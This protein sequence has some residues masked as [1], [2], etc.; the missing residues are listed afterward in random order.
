M[1]NKIRSA[2]VAA[3]TV[4]VLLV[5]SARMPA[6]TGS[7]GGATMTLP[8]TDVAGNPFFCQIA[9]AFVSGLTNGT[10]PTTYSPSGIVPR[11][12]MAAFITRTL[13]SAL[14]RGSR[15]AALRQRSL[16]NLSLS[17]IISIG[18][19]TTFVESDGT[20]LWVVAGTNVVRVRASDGT[21]LDT[22]T[23]A[24]SATALLVA[25][26][27]IFLAGP[28]HLYVIDPTMPG[29]SLSNRGIGLGGESV[30]ITT[31]GS[32]IWTAN[33][34][35]SVSRVH[36]DTGASSNFA[37]GFSKP[38]GILFDGSNLW[39]T[40]QGDNALKK[41][42]A[43]GNVIQNVP[44]GTAPSSPVFD[45]ANIWVPNRDDNTVTVVRAKDGLVLATLTGNGLNGPSQAAF[46]GQRTLVTSTT[47]NSVSLWKATD[48]TP[49]GTFSTG[50]F[51]SP[52][53]ACSDGINFWVTLPGIGKLARF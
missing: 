51:S 21:V 22:W 47:G 17:G 7:C 46:D 34:T 2:M 23:G 50:G 15:R 33:Y 35:G 41:L 9:E 1:R 25:R 16:S 3:T 24:A 42:D 37:T 11:E 14:A 26:G 30:G 5:T 10:T 19:F 38:A 13:D 36:P 4:A 52:L 20:D 40:D 12:Q 27:R 6:D 18:T 53:G 43:N 45:G 39:V 31:D 32:Y 28:G 29:G 8:F 44:V 49:I 48:L